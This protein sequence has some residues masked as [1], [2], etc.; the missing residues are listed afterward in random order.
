[1][2]VKSLTNLM[3]D[4]GL[5]WKD[6]NT[7]TMCS[8]G[9]NI[10][11]E[12]PLQVTIKDKIMEIPWK[13]KTNILGSLVDDTGDTNVMVQAQI[14]KATGAFYRDAE[15]LLC[16]NIAF[17]KKVSHYLKHVL[18]VAL[19]GC[20]A[21]ICKQGTLIL[22][23]GFETRML[24]L[25]FGCKKNKKMDWVMWHSL[26]TNIPNTYYSLIEQHQHHS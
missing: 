22:L 4:Y 18:P 14:Q 20:G 16:K 2:M 9:Y 19:H 10:T 6:G 26:A 11:E 15:L 5:K 13:N 17:T 23:H 3:N 7:K 1:M 21:W 24:K 8:G 12:M 25:M